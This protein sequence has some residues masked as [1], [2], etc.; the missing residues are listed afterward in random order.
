MLKIGRAMEAT[1][2]GVE[3]TIE[4]VHSADPRCGGT[5]RVELPFGSREF[6]V[7]RGPGMGTAGTTRTTPSAPTQARELGTD[8]DEREE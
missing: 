1:S 7:P 6:W 8:R 5:T 3:T 2:G 4:V